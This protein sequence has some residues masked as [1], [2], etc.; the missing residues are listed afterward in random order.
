MGS[1][2]AAT[3][4]RRHQSGGVRATR[5]IELVRTGLSRPPVSEA[6]RLIASDQMPDLLALDDELSL[7]CLDERYF[8]AASG[9]W[10]SFLRR[11]PLPLAQCVEVLRLRREVEVIV[12]WSEAVG[13]PVAMALLP[14]SRR[15][16]HVGIFMWVSKPKKA[17]PLRLLWRRFDGIVIPAPEQYRFAVERLRVPSTLA[18]PAIPWG[19]DTHFWRPGNETG[20]MICCVGREM[21]DYP[22]FVQAIRDLDIPCHIAAGGNQGGANPWLNVDERDLPQGVTLG[23]MSHLELRQLYH[24]SRF[25]VVP[26][27]PTDSD[28]GITTVLEAFAMGRPVICSDVV[29]HAGLLED[30][31]NCLLVPPGDTAALRAAIVRLWTDEPLRRRLGSAGRALVQDNYSTEHWIASIR[32]VME[33]AIE[34]RAPRSSRVSRRAG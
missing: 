10:G 25:V 31:V 5:R 22:T 27:L 32:V 2:A 24:R 3:V 11:V 18:S 7:E 26:L 16:A 8:A 6:R 30:D 20:D 9:V 28:N 23:R 14:F 17:L 15:P 1:S 12:S 4:R 19:V 34:A 33:K 13:M 21:R 29:G